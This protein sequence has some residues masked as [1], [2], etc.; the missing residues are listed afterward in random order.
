MG[1]DYPTDRT[2]RHWLAPVITWRSLLVQ[3]TDCSTCKL[4]GLA[5]SLY[6]NERGGSAFPAN[7]QLAADCSL[8]VSTVREHLNEHLHPQGWL[9]LIERGGLKGGHRR[10]NEWQAATPPDAGGIGDGPRQQVPRPRQQTASTP[11]DAGPQ[12]VQEIVQEVGAVSLV[13]RECGTDG[14]ESM[15]ALQDHQEIDC[16]ALEGDGDFESARQELRKSGGRG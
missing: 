7:A 14:F 13:C 4:V 3:G 2:D 11:P 6:M 5:L 12:V 8:G 10:A 15:L 16:P 9:V 1:A